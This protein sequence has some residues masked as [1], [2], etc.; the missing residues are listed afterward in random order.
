MNY[1]QGAMNW[2]TE[3]DWACETCGKNVGLEW[4]LV[5]AQCRCNECHTEYY[6]RNNDKE[7]TLR[8][9]PLSML[10]DDY[11]EPIKKAYERYGLPVDRLT[12]EQFDEFMN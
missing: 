1:W 10:K 9:V 12:D 3:R 11:K 7:R 5:H 4:G 2:P 6:M 8:T